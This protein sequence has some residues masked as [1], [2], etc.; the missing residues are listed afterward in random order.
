MG[1]ILQVNACGEE[2]LPR[3]LYW[4][5]PV[6]YGRY[7][8]E[9]RLYR[10]S[11]G[12]SSPAEAQE[13]LARLKKKRR[14]EADAGLVHD[15]S[16]NTAT[17]SWVDHLETKL[18]V[19][20]VERYKTSLRAIEPHVPRADVAEITQKTVANIVR[21]RLKAGVSNATIRRDLTAL[22][23]FLRWCVHQGFAES[24]AVKD[25]DRGV[26]GEKFK[27]IVLPEEDSF[28]AV[29]ERA[30]PAVA[31]IIQLARLTGMRQSEIVNLKHHQIDVERSCVTLTHTKGMKIRTVPLCKKALEICQSQPRH[32]EH[33]WLFWHD[34]G[35]PYVNLASRFAWITKALAE[36]LG[37]D[38]RP[39]NPSFQRFR[40]HDL[41]HLFAVEALRRGV[42]IYDL[43][44]IMGHSSIKVTERYLA[45]ITV[46]EA[47]RARGTK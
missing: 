29:I 5:G 12:T 28:K 33:P 10:E 2:K 18:S 39:K 40:F 46:E 47:H 36:E 43:Q 4:R 24:N 34:D 38:G 45:F 22:S 19:A 27:P 6:I 14:D 16:W 32:A 37:D 15:R 41:R 31:S 8:V 42:G 21:I 26:I 44:Q 1:S 11:L 25:Y 9:G 35:E 20:T 30:T 13:E 3:G 17:L 7:Q 23:S